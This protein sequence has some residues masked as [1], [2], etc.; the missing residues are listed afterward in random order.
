M[1]IRIAQNESDKEQVLHVRTAVFVN[2]QHVPMDEEV[3]A[4][5]EEAI[6][7][8]GVTNDKPV[9]T[10]R[11]RFVD[12]YGKLERISVLAAYRGQSFGKAMIR[13]MEKTIRKNGY[14]MAKLNAQTHAEAF[15]KHLGYETVSGTF[16]D[17]GIPHVTMTKYLL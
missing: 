17:A 16:L 15:Y 1:N 5:E 9:A 14:G 7:F 13:F 12:T 6:H 2:E 11:L 4:Y 10:G 8:L 3:D